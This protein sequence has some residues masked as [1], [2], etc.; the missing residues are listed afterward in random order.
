MSATHTNRTRRA[1]FL[2]GGAAA[3]TTTAGAAAAVDNRSQQALLDAKEREAIRE[4]TAALF[5]DGAL[6]SVIQ[7]AYRLMPSQASDAVTLSEDRLHATAAFPVEVEVCTPLDDDCTVAQMARLQGNV[8]E[9]HWERGRVEAKYVKA[10]GE[11]KIESLS[12]GAA[13]C[14]RIG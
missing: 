2:S 14:N 4:A 11:W 5:E 7:S 8:A 3:L 12:Y 9:R 13:S 6:A 1:F 10:Q